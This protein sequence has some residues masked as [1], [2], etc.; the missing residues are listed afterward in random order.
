MP[1]L[2][3]LA[4]FFRTASW[5]TM[6]RALLKAAG[7]FL[8][9]NVLFAWTYPLEVLGRLSLY[10]RLWPGRLR[11]PYGEDLA[12]SY[13]LSLYNVPA[14]FHSHALMQP[15]AGDE[16]RALVI[17]DSATWGWFLENQDTLVGRLNA[18][19]LQTA[20]GRRLVFYNLG[21]PV[22][23]L[24]K[25]LMLLDEGMRYEPDLILWPVTLESFARARQLD[26]PLLQH[27]PKRVRDLIARYDLALDP[28]DPRFVEPDFWGRTI[29]G[30]R[31]SLADLMRL[32]SLGLAW[33]ATGIDQAIPD[34]ISLRKSDFEKDVSWKDVEE[35]TTLD[36]GLLAF[37]VLAAGIARAGHA[38]ILIINEPMFISAGENSDLR[39]N[40]FYPRWAYDQYRQLLAQT[41][42]DQGWDYLDLWDAVPPREFTDT[43]VH[44]T[45]AGS[46]MLAELLTSKVL[47]RADALR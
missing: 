9:L 27:N 2:P 12:T 4:D 1:I 38:P 11:L 36:E 17:G 41:A 3:P 21:Y 35:P 16:F 30:Q 34:D 22:M 47:R 15:K 25:D 46:Q 29:V 44:L 7:I 33:A 14:M 37:D 39:Y 28:D 32:Q 20:D 18:A 5:S 6:G 23:S 8:I 40:S 13:N 45:P 42:Q 10:N 26:H 19:E 43:P 31:R 24:T